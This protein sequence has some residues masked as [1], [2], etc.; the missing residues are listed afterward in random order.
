M[1][2]ELKSQSLKG[3][4]VGGFTQVSQVCESL[5]QRAELFSVRWGQGDVILMLQCPSPVGS[6]APAQVRALNLNKTH[7]KI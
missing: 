5:R 2:S 4:L 1:V 6:V 3:E 7:K